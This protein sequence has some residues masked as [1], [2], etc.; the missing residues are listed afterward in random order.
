LRVCGLEWKH[1]SC[2][3]FAIN[4]VEIESINK[5]RERYGCPSCFLATKKTIRRWREG[6]ATTQCRYS[7]SKIKQTY[8]VVA[9]KASPI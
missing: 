2:F 5:N 7:W 3:I 1:S 6:E 9:E 4:S 8:I